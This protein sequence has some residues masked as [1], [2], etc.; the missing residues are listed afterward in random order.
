MREMR[1]ITY[2]H[3][4]LIALAALIMVAGKQVVGK[5]FVKVENSLRNDQ[6]EI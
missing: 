2:Y 5:L 6:P 1:F 3:H 4:V